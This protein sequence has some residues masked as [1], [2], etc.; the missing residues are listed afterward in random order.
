MPANKKILSAKT[1]LFKSR[2]IPARQ[3]SAKLMIVLHGRGDSI[4]PFL[5]FDSELKISDMNYLLLNA[6]RKFLG[7]WSWY[8]EP[9]YQKAG[10]LKI[11]EKLFELIADLELQGWKSENIYF[12]G[13]SQGCLISADFALHYPKRLG[14]VIG[15]SGYFHFFPRWKRHLT[16]KSVQTPWLFTHGNR[17][18]ILKI[19]E[20]RFGVQK[21]KSAGLKVQWVE[22]SKDH[23]LLEKEYPLIRS[24]I[25]G[26]GLSN[27]RKWSSSRPV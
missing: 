15:I 17:D 16:Q 4:R 7:G 6:P 1:N 11:R 24:W 26:K 3:T 20:T 12:F 19:D 22:M 10:V 21:L 14:G 9:P 23:V 25:R 5:E 13:F 27:R 8:G 2:F 18:D